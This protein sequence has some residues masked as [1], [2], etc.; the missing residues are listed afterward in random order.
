MEEIFELMNPSNTIGINR[1]LAHAVG[2]NAAVIYSA[3][4]SKMKYYLTYDMLNGGWFYSTI[5][6]LFESTSLSAHQQS[7]AIKK[8]TDIGLIQCERK[9]VPSKRYFY[10]N[11][12]AE[13]LSS[14]INTG[15]QTAN[16]VKPT[17]YIPKNEKKVVVDYS[18]NE[19]EQNTPKHDEYKRA[20]LKNENAHLKNCKSSFEKN[21]THTYINHKGNNLNGIQS[22]YPRKR[23]DAIDAIDLTEREEY[24]RYLKEK[25][26]YDISVER[27]PLDKPDYD[28]ILSIMLDVICSKKPYI[29]VNGDNMPQE[30]VKSAFLKLDESHIEY[31]LDSMRSN[32]TKVRNIRAYLVTALYNA[33][34]TISNY[35]R[36][37]VNYDMYRAQPAPA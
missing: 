8:L 23:E 2:I 21:A 34:S 19:S 36:S 1:Y 13:L 14:L 5:E 27:S 31:V 18:E 10:V 3:L 26:S 37:L 15:V 24:L 16:E 7:T 20:A 12:D 32:T 28:E 29:R 33:Q 11:N 25:L 6:D 35:Y 30:V 9:G 17:A 4:V 22:I